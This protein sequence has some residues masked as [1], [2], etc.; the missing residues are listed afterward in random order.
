MPTQIRKPANTGIGKR[1]RMTFP[2]TKTESAKA[3]ATKEMARCGG[4]TLYADSVDAAP[5]YPGMPPRNA[6]AKLPMPVALSSLSISNP[7]RV[8]A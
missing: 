7:S 4:A 6:E 8:T 1:L 3:A 2:S 5:T